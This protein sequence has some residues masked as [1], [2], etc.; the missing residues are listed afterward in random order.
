MPGDRITGHDPE[1]RVY[2]YHERMVEMTFRG[3]GRGYDVGDVGVGGTIQE[4][5]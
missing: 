3:T 2:L 5:V 1:T 4:C